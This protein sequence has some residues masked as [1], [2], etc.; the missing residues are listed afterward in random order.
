MWRRMVIPLLFVVLV[1]ASLVG[2]AKPAPSGV[3]QT[4]VQ[5]TLSDS[6][7]EASRTTFSPGI[8]YHFTVT[9]RG[10]H[11]HE[12]MI[13]RLGMRDLPMSGMDAMTVMTVGNLSPGETKA[14]D[15]TFTS[16]MTQQDLEFGCYYL[17]HQD[18]RLAIR[19]M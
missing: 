11:A 7:I 3:Q 14:L 10:T 16:A 19:V 8:P 18:L 1:T 6:R 12:L 9:N 13:D 5:V 17:G 4:D 2:C 15:F